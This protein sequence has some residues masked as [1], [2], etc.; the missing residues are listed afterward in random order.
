MIPEHMARNI[1]PKPKVPGSTFKTDAF[2]SGT[3]RSPS[4]VGTTRNDET[5]ESC[6][7][8]LITVSH[9]LAVKINNTHIWGKPCNTCKRHTTYSFPHGKHLLLMLLYYTWTNGAN[10]N[11]WKPQ[12]KIPSVTKSP[13]IYIFSPTHLYDLCTSDTSFI[14]LIIC[15]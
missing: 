15:N 2:C 7:P 8:R 1:W 5:A 13:K 4:K 10:H 11:F 6:P 3:W 12:L 9:I 14:I